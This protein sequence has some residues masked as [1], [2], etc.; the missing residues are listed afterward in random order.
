MKKAATAM[1]TVT[2]AFILL[3]TGMLIGR[4]T[5]GS[6]LYVHSEDTISMQET[7]PEETRQDNSARMDLNQMNLDQLVELPGIGP[8]IAQRILDYKEEHGPF[9]SVDELLNVKGI[10]ETR[11]TQLKEYLTV[12]GSQ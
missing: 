4:N 11:L 6:F 10:G 12:G 8:T 3:I 1:L 7:I 2:I 9:T 5:A